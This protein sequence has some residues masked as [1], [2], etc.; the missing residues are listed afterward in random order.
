MEKEKEI[1]FLIISENIIENI[2]IFNFFKKIK[3]K[4][5]SIKIIFILEKE[6]I[7]KIK[8]LKKLKIKYVLKRELNID[9]INEIIFNKNNNINRIKIN[10]KDTKNNTKNN[11]NNKNIIENNYKNKKSIEKNW[12]KI[13]EIILIKKLIEKSKKINTIKNIDYY[14]KK[15]YKYNNLKKI[16]KYIIKSEKIILFDRDNE[17]LKNKIIIYI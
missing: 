10:S 1:N 3:E 6:N 7:E 13:R 4:N 9:K 16:N 15:N 2:N 12:Q 17:I 8:I 11:K 14:I 5:M